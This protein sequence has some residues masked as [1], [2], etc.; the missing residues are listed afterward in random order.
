MEGKQVIITGA[1]SGIGFETAKALAKQGAAIGMVVRQSERSQQAREALIKSSGN[2]NIHLF[3][4]DLSLQSS[5]RKAADDIRSTFNTIDVLI[6]NA[7]TW[8]SNRTMTSEGI[9]MMF[10][11]NHLAYFLLT[12]LLLDKLEKSGA[13][14]I[15]NVSSDSHFVGKIRLNDLFLSKKYHGLKAYEQ[16]KLAN[17]LFTYELSRRLGETPITVNAVQ[18]GLVKTN[19]GHKHTKGIHSLA[20]GIRKLGGVTP[21]KGAATS[22]YLASSAACEKVS[23]K[24][25]DKCKP[26]PSAQISYDEA[27]ASALWQKCEELTSVEDYFLHLNRYST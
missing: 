13:G 5:I 20:W 16:S 8:I 11:V 18:P 7:G 3:F 25:W 23:G 4:T 21:A 6:N 24:Y 2:Q 12:H 10:A 17:V 9:E 22:I 15:I 26:K 1:N 27:L 14:R 19:I